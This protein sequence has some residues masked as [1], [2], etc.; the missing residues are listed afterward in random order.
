MYW[1]FMK[2]NYEYV[3]L[4]FTQPAE[5]LNTICQK[6]DNPVEALLE[7]NKPLFRNKA[8]LLQ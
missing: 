5:Y 3:T 7:R 4:V 8:V 2:N 6:E 1:K